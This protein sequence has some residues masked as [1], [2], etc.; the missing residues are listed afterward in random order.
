MRYSIIIGCEG[1]RRATGQAVKL[2]IEW[3]VN[4][5]IP[6]KAKKKRVKDFSVIQISDAV[7]VSGSV[8]HKKFIY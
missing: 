1:L 6:R 5:A 2:L 3:L 7:V 4:R 8:T